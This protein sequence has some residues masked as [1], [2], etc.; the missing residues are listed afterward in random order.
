MRRGSDI[1]SEEL[2]KRHWGSAYRIAFAILADQHLAE[3]I[4]Q[5]SMVSVL[6]NLRRF[7]LRRAFEPWLHRIVANRALDRA[8]SQSRETQIVRL[9]DPPTDRAASDPRLLELL[10]ALPPEQRTVVVMRHVAGYGTNEIAR[11]LGLRRGTV[12][13]RLRRGLDQLRR[14]LEE[15]DG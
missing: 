10:S 7:D 5:E 8:R 12:G 9:V 11:M 14:E 3:D 15:E 2:V 1:A 4:A 6:G 13:S